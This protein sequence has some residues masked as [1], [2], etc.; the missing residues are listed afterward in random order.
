MV[1]EFWLL[2][3]VVLGQISGFFGEFWGFFWSILVNFSEL[4]SVLA[5]GFS[6]VFWLLNFGEFWLFWVNYGN[7]FGE[8]E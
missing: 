2:N 8:F 7:F 5:V 6:I 3:L 4:W 1:A